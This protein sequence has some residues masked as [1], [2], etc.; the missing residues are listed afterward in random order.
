MASQHR[1][2]LN[3]NTNNENEGVRA[4]SV[5]FCTRRG[6]EQRY[7]N[8]TRNGPIQKNKEQPLCTFV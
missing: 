8:Q 2:S 3:V 5:L 1:V 7:L 4:G 6:S